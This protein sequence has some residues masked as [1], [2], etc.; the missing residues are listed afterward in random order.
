MRVSHKPTA[1]FDDPN[2]I[3]VAGLAP[4][5]ALAKR[6]GLHELVAEH[7]TVPGSAGSNAGQDPGASRRDG[8]RC[9]LDLGSGPVAAR[10]DG[11]AVR[12]VA[13]A[14]DVGHV[15]AGVSDCTERHRPHG[16]RPTPAEGRG[17]GAKARS[18]ARTP[19]HSRSRR[20]PSSGTS[21][22]TGSRATHAPWRRA[23]TSCARS[24]PAGRRPPT[25]SGSRS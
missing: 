21:R 7:V 8:R 23:V 6:A 1:V 15:P 11:P 25:A 19:T 12:R 20:P 14:D 13:G 3:S 18:P 10:R 9:G 5:M 22:S 24:S 4:V 17:A 16:A 2:L